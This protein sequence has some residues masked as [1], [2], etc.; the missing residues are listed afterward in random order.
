MIWLF[1]LGLA[2]LVH[3]TFSP[4]EIAMT[5]VVG[6]ASVAGLITSFRTRT[7]TRLTMAILILLIFAGLQLLAF[8]IS[9]L[10]AIAHR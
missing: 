2:Q 1:V 3:G 9:L 5:V 6:A 10:P 4:T 7:S 8:R